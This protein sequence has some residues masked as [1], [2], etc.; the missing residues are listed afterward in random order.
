MKEFGL[1]FPNRKVEFQFRIAESAELKQTFVR[2][3]ILGEGMVKM[4]IE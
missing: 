3:G 2:W 4:R 1:T